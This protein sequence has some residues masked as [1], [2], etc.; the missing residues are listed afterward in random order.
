MRTEAEE[1]HEA[2]L[3]HVL[4]HIEVARQSMAVPDKVRVLLVEGRV[5]IH[6]STA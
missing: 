5:E 4:S 2:L 3:G 1:P 6:V